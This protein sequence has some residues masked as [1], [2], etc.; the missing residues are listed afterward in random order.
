[1]ILGVAPSTRYS[2]TGIVRNANGLAM[3]GVP[4]SIN[5]PPMP[6][7]STNAAGRFALNDRPKGTY[8]VSATINGVLVG[9]RVTLPATTG[10]T[11]PNADIVLQPKPATTVRSY[12]G[13]GGSS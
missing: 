10:A 3:R 4:V 7:A 11:A 1:D 12:T 2:I 9:V 8:I 6:V 5:N 13:S